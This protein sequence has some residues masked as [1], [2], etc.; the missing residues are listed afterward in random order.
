MKNKSQQY[1]PVAVLHG[2]LSK[3]AVIFN[4]EIFNLKPLAF[5][6]QQYFH[7]TLYVYNYH[8]IT[9]PQHQSQSSLRPVQY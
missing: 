1:T 8:T 4:V 6:K 2:T 9:I 7:L 5:L 3:E